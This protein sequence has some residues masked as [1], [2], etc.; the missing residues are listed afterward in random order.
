MKE[1]ENV[2]KHLEN[3]VEKAMQHSSLEAPSLNFTAAIMS[4]INA[5]KSITTTYQPLITR[6]VW[7]LIGGGFIASLVFIIMMTKS[8]GSLWFSTFDLNLEKVG[9]LL[10]T[11]HL[12]KTAIYG[13][14]LFA[15]SL[16]VQI[17]ILKNYFDKRILN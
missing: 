1:N 13:I 9:D 7:I 4:Q 16:L 6:R 8:E 15:I 12:P 11:I 17:P 14:G 5:K 3:L 10:N 2:D